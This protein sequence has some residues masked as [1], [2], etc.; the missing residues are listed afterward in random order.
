MTGGI[1]AR[2]V[3]AAVVFAAVAAMHSCDRKKELPEMLYSSPELTVTCDSIMAKGHPLVRAESAAKVIVG[4]RTVDIPDQCFG[5]VLS[6]SSSLVD[7]AYSLGV[8]ATEAL[9]SADS[10][11][12]EE[13]FEIWQRG[14][15]MDCE[16]SRELLARAVSPGMTVDDAGWP[17]R[18][19]RGL[20]VLAALEVYR[21]G[22]SGEWLGFAS[23]VARNILAAD[24]AVIL[25]RHTGLVRGYGA[26]GQCN[27][28]QW[29]RW[30][31]NVGK[32]EC[33]T[34]LDNSIE[35][36]ACNAL[37]DMLHS[38]GDKD[39][40][41]WRSKAS[42]IGNAVNTYLWQPDQRRYG[43]FLYAGVYPIASRIADN[44]A[45]PLAMLLGIPTD[46]MCSLILRNTPRLSVGMPDFY[47][48][49]AGTPPVSASGISP[50]LESLWALAG[51]HYSSGGNV[52]AAYASILRNVFAGSTVSFQAAAASSTVA[53][54][55]FAG[56]TLKD[57]RLEFHPSVP[58]FLRHGLKLSGVK[59]RNSVLDINISGG[60]NRIAGFAVDGIESRAHFVDSALAGRHRVDIQLANNTFAGDEIAVANQEWT[61]GVPEIEWKADRK[62][63]ITDH[64]PGI[65]YYMYVNGALYDTFNSTTFT[66]PDAQA[67]ERICVVPVSK[68]GLYGLSSS[69]HDYILSGSVKTVQAED[70]AEGGTAL[71][72]DR[73]LSARFVETSE[74]CNPLIVIEATV[75]SGGNYMFRLCY[76]NGSAPER[77][78]IRSLRIN[79]KSAGAFVLPGRGDGWWLS[80]GY[81]N[82]LNAPLRAG[83]NVIEIG[84]MPESGDVIALIDYLRIT[85]L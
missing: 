7:A 25:D 9:L 72:R 19:T 31:D 82:A 58:H 56:L 39:S 8:S 53:L 34:L 27:A 44:V 1:T 85:A 29:P 17:L 74:K 50:M 3:M 30:M 70:F 32:Y 59:Y 18:T 21:A 20:W 57:D 12:A 10:V 14:A 16:R 6:T 81:S 45:Q 48:S 78:A 28:K 77:C 84:Y 2:I 62:G 68:S 38:L 5:P 67:F 61:P 4:D 43:E 37:A 46:E 64:S 69:P 47:P 52:D 75:A 83:V 79:G 41:V 24:T 55:V 23:E 54:R 35:A 33:M 63:V 76:A 22:G 11:G 26:I 71:V 36:G 60:G 51:A 65:M 73:R 80:T 40:T 15:L 42:D 66:L 13:W 49:P